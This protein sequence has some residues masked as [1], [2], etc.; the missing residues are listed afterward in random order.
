MVAAPI[1]DRGGGGGGSRSAVFLAPGFALGR[2]AP[3]LSER[4]F[5]VMYAAADY[6]IEH[7]NRIKDPPKLE[8]AIDLTIEEQQKFVAWWDAIAAGPGRDRSRSRVRRLLLCG[9]RRRLNG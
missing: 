8:E 5:R 3:P 9:R 4:R 6:R 7:A 1:G 2:R